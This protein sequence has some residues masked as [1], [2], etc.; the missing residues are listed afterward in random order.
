MGMGKQIVRKFMKNRL[1]VAGTVALI[2]ILTSAILAPLLTLYHPTEQDLLGR[3]QAPS[4]SHPLGTDEYGRDILTR[5]LYGARV[6]LL[7]GFC[8]VAGAILIG[9]LVGAFAGYYGGWMDNVLMRVVDLFNSFPSIFL[10]ITIVTLLEPS[11]TNIVAVFILLGWT[12]TARL[13][14]GEFLKLKEEEYVWAA[15]SLGMSD[16]RIMFVHM[17]PNAVAPIIVAAT[18]GVGGV[19]LAESGLSFL[20][21]GIQPPLPSWGNML[22]GAQSL[23]IMVL[24]P[25]YPLF[26]GLMILVTVLA[27]NF[28]GD[29][30]R[31]AFDPK[32]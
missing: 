1:A 12:G 3:L 26:P 7:V 11:L 9:T 30:L 27:F 32:A 22:Q 14:R 29:G 21:L 20:G 2:V 19:I 13:V 5:L 4:L 24:A 18:L 23:S 15:R 28:I 16:M 25:W 6:S 10:L 8:S 31:D 17:L